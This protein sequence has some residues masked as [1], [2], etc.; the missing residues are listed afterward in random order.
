MQRLRE[1]L[2]GTHLDET[3]KLKTEEEGDGAGVKMEAEE[4]AAPRTTSPTAKR[5]LASRLEVRR[6]LPDVLAH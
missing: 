4:D 6:F 2:A 3:V 1:D 5:R